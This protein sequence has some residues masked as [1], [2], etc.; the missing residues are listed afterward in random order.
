MSPGASPRRSQRAAAWRRQPVPRS[1]LPAPRWIC[2]FPP[3]A[4]RRVEGPL[5]SDPVQAAERGDRRSDGSPPLRTSAPRAPSRREAVEASALGWARERGTISSGEPK[6][7]ACRAR[8]DRG[9]WGRRHR[10]ALGR[11]ARRGRHLLCDLDAGAELA[12][13]AHRRQRRTP[14]TKPSRARAPD[15]VREPVVVEEN[16]A[17]GYGHRHGDRGRPR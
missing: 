3:S 9:V 16:A 4:G 1:A 14:R 5:P 2:P 15:H 10:G 7:F 11:R 17:R 12:R 6:A 8:P 13:C